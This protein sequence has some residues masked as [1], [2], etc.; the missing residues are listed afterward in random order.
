MR[1]RE[2]RFLGTTRA[3]QLAC[4]CGKLSKPVGSSGKHSLPPEIIIK[5]LTRMGWHVGDNP[6]QDMCPECVR[7]PIKA[8]IDTAGKALND[9][10]APMVAVNGHRVHFTELKVAAEGLDAEC[11]KELIGILQKQIPPKPPKKPK[12]EPPPKMAQSAYE[13]WL[14]EL[15]REKLP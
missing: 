15:E 5:K 7:K 10:M 2:K 14:D 11:A 6:R 4:S 12:P 13:N 1:S 8:R 9:A 3:C